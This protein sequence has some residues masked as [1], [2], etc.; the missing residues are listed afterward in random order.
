[1]DYWSS[2]PGPMVQND[3]KGNVASMRGRWR[4]LSCVLAA[5]LGS[6]LAGATSE[7]ATVHLD[8]RAPRDIGC[9][10][11]ER[12]RRSVERRLKRPVFVDEG[13]ADLVVVVTYE[14]SV[15]A[16]SIE[17]R[18]STKEGQLLGHRRL[19]AEGTDCDALD[20]SVALVLALMV[21]LTRE[22]VAARS[23]APALRVD[24]PAVIPLSPQTPVPPKAQPLPTHRVSFQ[25]VA[26][27]GPVP[28]L[29]FGGRIGLDFPFVRT[30][31][32][33]IGVMALLPTRRADGSERGA[34]FD[35][36]AMDTAL[37]RALGAWGPSSLRLCGGVQFGRLTSSGY[38]Y[39]A[40]R[41]GQSY[42]VN[43]FAKVQ[44]YYSFGSKVAL[45]AAAGAA[46]ATIRD[47]IYVSRPDGAKSTLFRPSTIEP[48]V[49]FGVSL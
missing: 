35:L 41:V 14:P 47:E 27:L 43:P 2:W 37:C 25:S 38:G 28:H 49:A 16:P 6:R 12:T 4:I 5:M 32:V 44:G 39:A 11:S 24:S 33:E 42:L 23:Q 45:T 1:M 13:D 26:T 36:V 7:F 40:D 21:D 20:D 31:V 29:A 15:S 9:V 30:W 22:R 3:K 17:V 48:F 19:S 34:T 8:V 46:W 10:T 18:L